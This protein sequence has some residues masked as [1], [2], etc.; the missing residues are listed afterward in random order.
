MKLSFY[1]SRFALV[2]YLAAPLSLVAQDQLERHYRQKPA[3]V[4]ELAA[5]TDRGRQIASYDQAAWHATDAVLELADAKARVGMYIGRQSNGGWVV[6]FGKLNDAKDAFLLAY[7]AVPTGDVLHPRVINYTPE[8]EDRGEWLN[9]AL[10]F[11]TARSAMPKSGRQYNGTVLDGPDMSSWYVYFYPAQTTFDSFPTGADI[12]FRVSHDGKTILE[13]H[14]MH[15]DILEYDTKHKDD[16][17]S[18]TF[19]TA[20]LDEAP[21]DTDVANVLMMGRIPMTIV[22]HSFTYRIAA[23]GTSTYFMPTD[24]FFKTEQ[25]EKY[26]KVL[27][28]KP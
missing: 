18:S 23:D 10:A 8:K 22:T 11:N 26:F 27:K 16:P 14:H 20:Y 12:R 9:E 19:H 15:Q 17:T 2:A 4:A 1:W 24:E 21:E 28:F 5:I 3:D 7:E 6:G 13:T 25:G